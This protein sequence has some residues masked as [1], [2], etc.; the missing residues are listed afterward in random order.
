MLGNRITVTVGVRARNTRTMVP[1]R[2]PGALVGSRVNS[3]THKLLRPSCRGYKSL[4]DDETICNIAFNYEL[5]AIISFPVRGFK[6]RESARKTR[7][8]WFF[9]ENLTPTIILFLHFQTGT[10]PSQPP[11]LTHSNLTLSDYHC[12]IYVDIKWQRV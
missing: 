2:P 12:R 7:L 11:S 1:I 10:V 6:V 3:P 8:Q 9:W 5:N 4:M